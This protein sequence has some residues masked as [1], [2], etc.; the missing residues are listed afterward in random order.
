MGE[1]IRICID[2]IGF[3]KK[4]SINGD[5]WMKASPGAQHSMS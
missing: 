5:E 3:E 1:Q 4:F 2:S